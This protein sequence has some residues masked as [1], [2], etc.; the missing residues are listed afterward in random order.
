MF[1]CPSQSFK[2]GGERHRRPGSRSIPVV[3]ATAVTARGRR[4]TRT[5]KCGHPLCVATPVGCSA[6]R[7]SPYRPSSP[8]VHEYPQCE[9]LHEAHSSA[10]FG[11]GRLGWVGRRGHLLKDSGH[12]ELDADR[13]RRGGPGT[14]SRPHAL[15]ARRGAFHRLALGKFVVERAKPRG[16][17]GEHPRALHRHRPGEHSPAPG[18]LLPSLAAVVW[19]SSSSSLLPY[20]PSEHPRGG[21][22]TE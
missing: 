4:K 11:G 18:L 16:W 6:R 10:G 1:K 2:W 5:L 3:V 12:P 8:S 7:Q 13:G 15:I 17:R 22:R 9:C 14:R 20:P 19:A 21:V